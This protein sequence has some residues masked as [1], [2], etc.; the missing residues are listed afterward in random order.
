MTSDSYVCAARALARTLGD[1]TV[2]KNKA[3]REAV[4]E[5]IIDLVDQSDGL[6]SALVGSLEGLAQLLSLRSLARREVDALRIYLRQVMTLS[7]TRDLPAIPKRLTHPTAPPR[8]VTEARYREALMATDPG[9]DLGDVAMVGAV[10]V[11]VGLA[12][13][14]IGALGAAAAAAAGGGLVGQMA[15]NVTTTVAQ[16]AVEHGVTTVAEALPASKKPPEPP[17][18]NRKLAKSWMQKMGYDRLPDRYI[19]L[20]THHSRLTKRYESDLQVWKTREERYTAVRARWDAALAPID[21]V[22]PYRS[23]AKDESTEWN[24]A[25]IFGWAALLGTPILALTNAKQVAYSLGLSEVTALLLVALCWGGLMLTG[26]GFFVWR[27]SVMLQ[28]LDYLDKAPHD[29]V[30][31]AV[32]SRSARSRGGQRNGLRR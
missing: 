15:G 25:K 30:A 21:A 18:R 16:G 3:G 32:N 28:S 24:V 31:F 12:V 2:V 6:P 20:R 13:S 10:L 11:G 1:A 19:D 8:L 7:A 4:R 23:P 5:G 26:F 27:Q 17:E 14:G 29:L 22:L 9:M